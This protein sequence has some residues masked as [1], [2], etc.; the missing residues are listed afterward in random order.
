MDTDLKISVVVPVINEGDRIHSTLG[1]LRNL[2][3]GEGVEIVLVDG[4]PEGSTIKALKDDTVLR[5]LSEKGRGM[6]MNRGASLASG[7]I[8]LFL[9][10]DT[11]LPE[12]AFGKIRSALKDRTCIGG[13]F[14]LAIDSERFIFRVIENLASLRSRLTRVPYGDQAIFMRR[15]Y[16]ESIGKYREIPLME[17]VELMRRIKKRGERIRI[18]S[19]RVQTSP[20]RWE[21]E[22]VLYCTLR[23]WALRS[24]YL[25]GVSP[26]RLARF[27]R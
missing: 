17:D 18:L 23:N 25:L 13:A 9:H 21:R 12:D 22:G 15:D 6:Q 24:L 8:L 5:T 4:S 3:S 11:I 1:R 26:H 16:F 14:D 27:Y 10:A 19:E 2:E 20:R 7:D